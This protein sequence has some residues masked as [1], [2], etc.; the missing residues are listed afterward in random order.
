MTLRAARAWEAKYQAGR[1][2]KRAAG[3]RAGAQSRDL[4]PAHQAAD[5]VGQRPADDRPHRAAVDVVAHG[6]VARHVA[7]AVARRLARVCSAPQRRTAKIARE[8]ESAAP[9]PSRHV[10]PAQSAV[11]L[12]CHE[13]TAIAFTSPARQSQRQQQTHPASTRKAPHPA[14]VTF[15]CLH[16]KILSLAQH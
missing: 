3:R 13:P 5:R 6:A 8:C 2:K 7:V 16:E 1:L 4:R 12:H 11:Q 10:A 15:H 14:H 9:G